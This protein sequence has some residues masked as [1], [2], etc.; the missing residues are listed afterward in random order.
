MP[1]SAKRK[2]AES[3]LGEGNSVWKGG[4]TIAAGGYVTILKPNHPFADVNGRI[5]EERLIMEKHIGRYLKPEEIIHHKNYNKMDNRIENLE[6]MSRS[7]H[8]RYHALKRWH[9]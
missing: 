2:I 8:S 5:K 6:I 1:E 4:R 3:Q 9:G 7:E